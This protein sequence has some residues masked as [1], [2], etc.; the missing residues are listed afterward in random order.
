MKEVTIRTPKGIRKIGPGRAAFII[1]EMSG[2]HHQSL[3]QAMKI[4]DAAAASGV[5]SIKLQTFKPGE[6]TLD[7]DN[8]YF[9]VKVNKAWA[10]QTL[11]SLYQKVYTP[12]EWQAKLKKYGESK[13]LLVF[14]TPA[15]ESAVDFLEKLKMPLYKIGS[16][17][18]TD[19]PLLERIGRTKKPVIISRGMASEAEVKL[20]VKT[21]RAAGAPEVAVLH[22]ISSYPA[23]PEEM[24]IAT[25]PALAKKLKIPIGLSDHSLAHTASVAAVALGACIIEKHFTLLR[26]DGGPDAAFSLEPKEMKQLVKEIRETEAAIGKPLLK[27]GNRELENKIFRHSLF[28]ALDINKG[29]KITAANVKSVRPGFGLEPKFLKKVMGRKVKVNLKKGTPLRWSHII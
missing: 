18:L 4:V 3:K 10:G 25:I 27:T 24:N 19:T 22:C 23:K 7:C 9:Q 28:V 1:A 26:S 2:N 17:E 13:G 14:S 20:A 8:K 29:Q 15:H 16:F 6:I 21:L 5:D 12:W 11:Y